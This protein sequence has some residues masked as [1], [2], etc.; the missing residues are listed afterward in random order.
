MM[1]KINKLKDNIIH[2]NPRFDVVETIYEVN[3]KEYPYYTF[4]ESKGNGNGF[5]VIIGIDNNK[6]MMTKQFRPPIK[7]VSYEFVG[8]YIE[9][10][11]KAEDA[12]RREFLEETGYF[13]KDLI[14]LG[15]VKAGVNKSN[16]TGYVYLAKN[17]VFKGKM[18]D[19]FEKIVELESSW[20]SLSK[21]PEVIRK[22][23]IVDTTTLA[24]WSLFNSK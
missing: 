24:A 6:V 10:K 22:G 7:R 23:Y 8:G 2:S 4:E 9:D 17:F 12:A 5:V 1:K 18:L 15:N 14:K 19:E 16:T 20:V 3:G 21:I 11:E 13:C